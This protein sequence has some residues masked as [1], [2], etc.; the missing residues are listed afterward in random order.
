MIKVGFEKEY[1]L[2]EDGRSNPEPI[3]IPRAS[4]LPYDC[5]G[6][7]LEARGNPHNDVT[8]AV[9]SL[10]ADESRLKDKLAHYNKKNDKNYGISIAHTMTVPKRTRIRVRREY[11]K[12]LIQY[13]NLY[14]HE[15]HEYEGEQSGAGVHVSFTNPREIKLEHSSTIVNQNFDW[16]RLFSGLDAAFKDEIK[17]SHRLPGFYE[18]K[19]DGRIEYRSLPADIDLRKVKEV[20]EELIREIR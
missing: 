10:L 19:S 18:L 8:E 7:L 3:I 13:Q 1:F 6:W 2:V 12:G 5:C 9:F 4:G 17:A 20:L 11:E 15:H 16:A 14:G